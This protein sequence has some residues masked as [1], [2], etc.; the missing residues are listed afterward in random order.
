MPFPVFHPEAWLCTGVE[1]AWN[2]RG[3][4]HARELVRRVLADA[5][6]ENVTLCLTIEPDG[7]PDCL[8]EQQLREWYGR[9]GFV[10]DESIDSQFAM[11]RWPK[12]LGAHSEMGETA[13]EDVSGAAGVGG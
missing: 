4:G 10:N 12:N 8:T 1:V 3:C 5:D 13:A 9:L 2:K 11:V 6:A 7:S